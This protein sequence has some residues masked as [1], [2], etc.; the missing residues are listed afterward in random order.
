MNT[1]IKTLGAIACLC[2]GSLVMLDSGDAS[3]ATRR[4]GVGYCGYE[5]PFVVNPS[6]TTSSQI[7]CTLPSDSMLEHVSI[8]DLQVYV[9]NPTGSLSKASACVKAP[10]GLSY[11]CDGNDESS[12]TFATLHPDVTASVLR[13]PN[14]WYWFPYAEVSLGPQSRLFGIKLTDS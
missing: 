4:L 2:A 9:H 6:L 7:T 12:D 14:Y 11:V 5:G 3:A 10:S 8:V 1:M 13:N